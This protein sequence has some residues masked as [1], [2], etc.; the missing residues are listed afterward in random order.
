MSKTK[1]R[2]LRN[3]FVWGLVSLAIVALYGM[4]M[5]YKILFNLPFLNQR[6]LLHA[7]S[8][9]A[10]IGWVSHFLFT[11][12]AFVLWPH[13]P[14]K[15]KKKYPFL[16]G[17]NW[18]LSMA[19]LISFTIQGYAF[20][21]ILFLTLQMVYVVFYAIFYI[22]DVNKYARTVRFRRWA[23]TSLILNILSSGGPMIIAYSI[24][25]KPGIA[26]LNVVGLYYY[27][28]FQYNGWF[29]FGI[30]ALVV[31]MLPDLP[32]LSRYLNLFAIT[33]IPTLLL[34]LLWL[35]LPMWMYV[36]AVIAIFVEFGV[37]IS[38]LKKCSSK[39]KISHVKPKWI[40]IFFYSAIIAITLKFTLQ[41]ISIVPSLSQLV[42]GFRP[43]V[44]GYLHLILLGGYSL[45]ILGFMFYNNFL[46]TRFSTKVGAFTFF[47]G[48]L[49]NEGVLA[50][51]GFAAFTYTVIPYVNQLLL[52][53]A[54]L[55][56]I[57]AL[58]MAASEIGYRRR[59]LKGEIE[60]LED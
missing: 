7:H 29:F 26:N 57:G 52:V 55:L 60:M 32:R 11:G 2:V 33:A 18:F 25:A 12:L 43:I 45:F 15:T 5:R 34:S 28:H 39:F 23:I 4:T 10:F 53:A 20:Y 13:I 42:F 56:F 31:T 1:S 59:E 14:H 47:I 37:W 24:M 40:Q 36:I 17:V 6:N 49:L 46:V 21:S 8:H 38:F 44:I 35:G 50:I 27:L 58:M 3:W 22:I 41:T 19:I 16:I 30:M 51:Q 54:I 9:F 48:V